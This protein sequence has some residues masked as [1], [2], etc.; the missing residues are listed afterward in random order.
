M[1]SILLILLYQ[2]F[3]LLRIQTPNEM[4]EVFDLGGDGQ[5]N[6][7]EQILIFQLIKEKMQIMA[8]ELCIV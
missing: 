8:D 2:I 7:D 6:E 5:L 4:I 3:D 1:R